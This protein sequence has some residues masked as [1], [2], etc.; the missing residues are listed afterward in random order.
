MI[1]GGAW[2]KNHI[3]TLYDLGHLGGISDS[4]KTLISHYKK[5][6]PDVLIYDNYKNA[7]HNDNFEGFVV[8]TPA[9][10]HYDIVFDFSSSA[11][12]F[13]VPLEFAHLHF[14]VFEIEI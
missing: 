1:G 2:G 8:A 13:F 4:N 12:M 10:T 5:K 6:Y 7:L 11:S 14:L 3:K 9:Q